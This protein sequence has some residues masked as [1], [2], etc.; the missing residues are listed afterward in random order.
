MSGREVD[1]SDDGMEY[2]F[3][4]RK[5]VKFHN[6]EELK[7]SDVKYTFERMLT[8]QGGTNSEFLDQIKG[9]T[10]LLME[11]QL[12]WKALKSW[13]ITPLS[14]PLRNR[15]PVSWPVSPPR[16]VHLQ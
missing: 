1:I 2:T 11:R 8:V 5:G 12:S 4:L 3:Y 15:I 10:E 16:R 14:L 13:M 6:G 7:A 9:S